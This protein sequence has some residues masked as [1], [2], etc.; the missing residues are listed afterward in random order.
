M[1]SRVGIGSPQQSPNRGGFVGETFSGGRIST[2]AQWSTSVT[3]SLWL[4]SLLLFDPFALFT[5]LLSVASVLF[6]Y[7][8][9]EHYHHA[10]L[11]YPVSWSVASF[12]VIFPVTFT[13]GQSFSR[14]ERGNTCLAQIKS[15]MIHIYVAHSIWDWDKTK[16]GRRNMP[17]VHAAGVKNILLQ[18]AEILND[19]LNLPPICPT[20][21]KDGESYSFEDT[22][23]F[24]ARVEERRVLM[25]RM[26]KCVR[27]LGCCVELLKYH[28]LPANEASR[29]NQ[30]S[31][32]VQTDI[33]DAL[34]LKDFR[35]PL[36]I[37]GEWAPGVA[38]VL[39]AILILTCSFP[40]SSLGTQPPAFVQ[41]YLVLLPIFY[42]PNYAHMAK[43]GTNL[44]FAICFSI[45]ISMALVGLFNV[46]VSRIHV[47]SLIWIH[48]F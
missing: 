25:A 39:N 42:G 23:K 28:G 22:E 35:T 44:A 13:I 21:T 45:F 12:V 43:H 29:V 40:L 36:R 11:S 27:E 2:T 9:P 20:R 19:C 32:M 26:M 1:Y 16:N 31:H 46:Q 34:Q 5:A 37:R 47:Q 30:Y 7:Y 48:L 3:T 24:G 17:A 38:S 33:N 4:F 6:Y 41:I 18:Q 15:L 10:E 8:I 14:R